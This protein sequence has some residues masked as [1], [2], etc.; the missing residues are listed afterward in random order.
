MTPE[1]TT[2][3]LAALL[4]AVQFILFAVPANRELGTGYTS[5]ARD[6]PPSRP[7]SD[8]TGRLQRA[9]NNHFEGLILFTIAVV[10][11]TL[12]GQSTGFTAACAWTYLAAR[13][14]FIPAYAYGWR[15]W[16]SAIWGVGF[17]ATLAMIVA[18]LV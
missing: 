18:A 10:V 15:P 9:M 8:R 6:R 13:V 2:L 1:L 16:R 4:Q 7:L 5:S 14:L 17:F 12:G 3:A 11:V